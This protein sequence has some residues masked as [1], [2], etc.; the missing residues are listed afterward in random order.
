LGDYKEPNKEVDND[1]WY[2][3]NDKLPENTTLND[4]IWMA[5]RSSDDGGENW[6]QW[7][8]TRIRGNDGDSPYLIEL[9]NDSATVGIDVNG[10]P[11]GLKEATTTRVIVYR[12][13]QDITNDC[14]YTWSAGEDEVSVEENGKK[15]ALTSMSADT[16]ELT[17]EVKYTVEGKTVNIGSKSLTVSK[18]PSTA[19]YKLVATP[20][21]INMTTSLREITFK[22]IKYTKEQ[23]IEFSEP[24]EDLRIILS[25]GDTVSEVTITGFLAEINDS[26][27]GATFEL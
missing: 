21:V 6:T 19:T 2:D 18:I 27:N 23:S 12:G 20:Q 17:V 11:I 14:S 7:V 22:V 1:G 25:A 8:V 16:A 5:T 10:I 13:S 3:P 9:T 4:A 15:A 26:F 24:S